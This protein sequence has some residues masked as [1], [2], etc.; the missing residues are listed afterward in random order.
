MDGEID[1]QEDNA[2]NNNPA[3]PAPPPAPPQ[4]RQMAAKG[5]KL[6]VQPFDPYGDRLDLGKKWEKWIERFERDLKY[7][8]IDP[9]LPQNSEMAK[10]ALMMYSGNHTED[11]HD[12]IPEVVK[13]EEV[14]DDQWTEYARSKAKLNGY[15]SPIKSNDFALFE[16]MSVKPNV[17]EKVSSY[18][19]RLRKAAEKCDFANWSAQKMIKCV[20]ISNISDDSM[21]LKFLKKEH[22]LEE[23]TDIIR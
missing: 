12:T 20:L 17:E 3:P 21:R 22:T 19:T 5:P 14:P 9:S 18:V 10:M 15:F 4:R 1:E 16:L 2:N 11:I 7:N 6:K 8:G 13:P 23:I